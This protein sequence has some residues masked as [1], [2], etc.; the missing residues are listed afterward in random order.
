MGNHR[1][2]AGHTGGNAKNK[3]SQCGNARN[4]GGNLG[5]RVEMAYNSS[6]NDKLNKW[7]KVKIIENERICK[8][9]V[10]HV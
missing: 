6:G 3:E 2:Y 7:R 8:S 4:Q 9:L 10:S 1:R 5:I